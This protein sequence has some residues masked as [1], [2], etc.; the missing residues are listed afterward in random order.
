MSSR[1]LITGA[2]GFIGQALA[3]H[4]LRTTPYTVV[5]T[6]VVPPPV[7]ANIPH[8]ENAVSVTADLRTESAQV[9]AEAGGE[10]SHDD[11]RIDGPVAVFVLHGIMSG[12]AE[13]DFELG[14]AVNVDATRALLDALRLYTQR[15]PRAIP[16]RVVYASSLAVFGPPYVGPITEATMPI[17]QSS[18]GAEKVVCEVL[19]S[20]YSRRG[21]IDGL[22][23]R[24]PTVSVRPGAPAPAASAFLSGLVREPLNREVAVVPIEDDGFKSWI[25]SPRTLLENLVR[26]MEVEADRLSDG[27]GRQRRIVNLPGITV[28]IEEMISALGAKVGKEALKFIERKKD[29]AAERILMSWP[30][31]FDVSVAEDMGFHRDEGFGQII[32]DYLDSLGG[33]DKTPL[34]K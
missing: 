1:V 7:P 28:T 2:A 5:L 24:F 17:P 3:S 19:V 20:E 34:G 29:P 6:D 30:T 8:P 32:G 11:G 25:C 12:R 27:E 26:A 10:R 23:C 16:P 21:W 15:D 22:V 33:L 14:M 13:A 9:V 31:D 18:Y 4:L